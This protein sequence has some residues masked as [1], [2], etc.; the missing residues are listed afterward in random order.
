M[1]TVAPD[2]PILLL[3]LYFTFAKRTVQKVV[4]PT[5]GQMTEGKGQRKGKGKSHASHTYKIQQATTS[6]A[7]GAGEDYMGW[8]RTK[9]T[10]SGPQQH[11]TN[12]LAISVSLGGG[13]I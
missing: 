2:Q 9:R 11:K 1:G 4:H 7:Q 13:G 8:N 6:V 10:E 5:P 12:N 3:S